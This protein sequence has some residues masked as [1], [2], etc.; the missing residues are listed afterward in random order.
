MP[1]LLVTHA[2]VT[3]FAAASHDVSPLHVDAAYAR[4][5]S[6]GR[7]V[8]H[9]VRALLGAMSFV[10]PRGDVV[11]K[12]TADFQGPVFE[13]APCEVTI[14]DKGAK[15]KLSVH[16]GT[17]LL[18]RA[19]LAYAAGTP[20]ELATA[21]ATRPRER[22]RGDEV[23]V[24]PA[25]D[26]AYAP[27]RAGVDAL[28]AELDLRARGVASA[29]VAAM[30]AGSYVVGME[31]PG[32]QALFS[33]L[34]LSFGAEAP[35]KI[36]AEVTSFDDRFQMI[37]MDVDL[38]G[39]RGEIRAL[40][41]PRPLEIDAAR[42]DAALGKDRPLEGRTAIV[43][44]AG[45]GLGAAIALALAKA[46]ARVVGTYAAA[47]ESADRLAALDARL[48]LVRADATNDAAAANVA[49]ALAGA[50]IDLLV[51]SASPPVL[52]LGIA[53][54]TADRVRGFVDTSLAMVLVPLV[55]LGSRLAKDA[56][57]VAISSTYAHEPPE[58][59]AHYA[60][61]K[62]AVEGLLRG[63]AKDRSL[64]LVIVRPPRILTDM[65]NTAFGA[66]DALRAEDVAVR[67]VKAAIDHREGVGIVE[68]F[69]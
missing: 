8:V 28:V 62:G 10:A 11:S 15:V 44:G 58:D 50:S 46:G 32:E 63:F 47:K 36:R 64:P 26:A 16:D 37:D 21:T 7:P 52:P 33:R 27:E 39:A 61:A 67:I 1:T 4:R 3:A 68:G 60:A 53:P 17:R 2:D 24:G 40:V 22:A 57:V 19:T 35:A 69:G 18:M 5:T 12:V 34:Q 38:C 31:R 43:I 41:R 48:C 30:M 14:D 65:T 66:D 29:H 49:E 45:R 55:A 13:D 6:F 23:K 51:L 56:R 59:F 9:G 20:P 54:A 42:I 25:V